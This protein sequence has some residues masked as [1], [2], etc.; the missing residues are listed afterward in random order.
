MNRDHEVDHRGEQGDHR[1]RVEVHGRDPKAAI[2]ATNHGI[3][4]A[5]N[6]HVVQ[7]ENDAEVEI[8]VVIAE[9]VMVSV[10]EAAPSPHQNIEN[11]VILGIDRNPN[12]HVVLAF[13]IWAVEQPKMNFDA[14]SSG[15]AKLSRANWFM[16]KSEMNHVDLD[17]VHL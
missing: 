2:E 14:Y 17:F 6:D 10:N 9:V 7:V 16:I 8:A 13:S 3:V 1:A 5:D 15:M 11:S 4:I 12:D